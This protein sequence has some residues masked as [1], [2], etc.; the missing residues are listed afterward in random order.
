MDEWSD[1]RAIAKAKMAATVQPLRMCNCIGPQ[2][3]QPVCP[4]QMQ[5]VQVVDGRY[6]LTRDLGPAPP[7]AE[8]A[9]AADAG[10]KEG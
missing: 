7:P 10:G 6:V 8:L 2:R 9:R 4:C 5:H 3:G 1:W